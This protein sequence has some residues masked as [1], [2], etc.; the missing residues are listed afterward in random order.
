LEDAEPAPQ[1]VDS[2]P[3]KDT[4]K[5]TEDLRRMLASAA[6]EV[7]FELR[8]PWN[9]RELYK[10]GEEAAA[11]ALKEQR[12][13]TL[14]L[15]WEE[16]LRL[17]I[18]QEVWE[19]G[20]SI[21]A[22]VDSEKAP[23]SEEEIEAALATFTA[24]QWRDLNPP[25]TPE[26][27]KQRMEQPRHKQWKEWTG[28]T[29]SLSR[30]DVDAV[31]THVYADVQTPDERKQREKELEQRFGP[32][33]VNSFL[34]GI[35]MRDAELFAADKDERSKLVPVSDA[36]WAVFWKDAY[37]FASVLHVVRT[38]QAMREGRAPEARGSK[39]RSLAEGGGERATAE[40][41]TKRDEVIGREMKVTPYMVR[42]WRKRAEELPFDEF[43]GDFLS[44]LRTIYFRKEFESYLESK[45]N[46]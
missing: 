5:R 18:S 20:K 16:F 45:G 39:G 25:E 8:L 14:G 15:S 19:V 30:S 46:K 29:R 32:K 24:K 27:R 41:L 6:R 11:A 2:I 33:K 35:I 44:Y 42:Q 4:P 17:R 3:S 37:S 28:L 21:Q 43:E 22:R 40:R 13:S 12:D 34:L 26:Q 38:H 10:A 7:A 23:P 1:L 36:Y 9:V 31:L